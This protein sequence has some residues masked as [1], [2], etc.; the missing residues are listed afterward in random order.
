MSDS[1]E[2]WIQSAVSAACQRGDA[3]AAIYYAQRKGAYLRWDKFKV[4]E[5]YAEWY[6][7]YRDQIERLQAELSRGEL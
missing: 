3:A 1:L 5:G 7:L 2:E 6:R 4:S